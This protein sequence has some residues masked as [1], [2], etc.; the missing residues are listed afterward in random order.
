MQYGVPPLQSQDQSVVASL[1][2]RIIRPIEMDSAGP[3][4]YDPRY[5]PNSRYSVA[6]HSRDTVLFPN[7]RGWDQKDID[8]KPGEL[9]IMRNTFS[10][11]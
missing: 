3:E 1:S 8:E 5:P 9:E 2:T 6:G 10:V 7:H 11:M 4:A